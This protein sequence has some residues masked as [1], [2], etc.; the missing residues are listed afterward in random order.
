[1]DNKIIIYWVDGH[2]PT[3]AVRYSRNGHIKEYLE[4]KIKAS[5]MIFVDKILY[6]NNLKEERYEEHT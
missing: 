3:Y 1:M 4:L 2:K 6:G 5:V